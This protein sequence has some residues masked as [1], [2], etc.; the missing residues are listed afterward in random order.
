MGAQRPNVPIPFATF[1]NSVWKNRLFGG[2]IISLILP[3]PLCPGI[4]TEGVRR[5]L[6]TYPQGCAFQEKRHA[7]NAYCSVQ[8][9]ARIANRILIN[10]AIA[11]NKFAV[12]CAKRMISE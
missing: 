2:P 4:I 5:V 10:A 9:V 1:R 6:A 7:G 3:R 11:S 12:A 8:N